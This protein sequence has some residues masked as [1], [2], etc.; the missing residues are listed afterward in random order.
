MNCTGIWVK[1][2]LN[3]YYKNYSKTVASPKTTQH[4]YQLMKTW[5]PA[6]KL[7]SLGISFLGSSAGASASSSPLDW[8]E[9]L[10]GILALLTVSQQSLLLWGGRV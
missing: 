8:S 10:L 9:P 6:S 7:N 4:R 2:Y 3:Y 1:G 5:K